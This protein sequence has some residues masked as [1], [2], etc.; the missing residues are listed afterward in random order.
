MFPFFPFDI[1]EKDLSLIR[2]PLLYREI[3]FNAINDELKK[4]DLKFYQTFNFIYKDTTPMYTFGGIF[5]E[6]SNLLNDSG[7]FD[8]NFISRSNEIVEIN[9][10][11][12]TPLEKICFDQLIPN[13]SEKLSNLFLSKK[14]LNDY[15]K[16]YK[17]YPQYFESLI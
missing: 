5:E 12:I 17:Y 6:D 8:L 9:L 14:Q 1:K 7:L 15:E 11:I 4:R 3:L 10:P 16:Y 2:L 13:I